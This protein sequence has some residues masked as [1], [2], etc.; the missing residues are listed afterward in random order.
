M[1]RP[2]EPT[3]FYGTQIQHLQWMMRLA[4]ADPRFTSEELGKLNSRTT[5]ITRLL[6]D[7]QER[8]LNATTVAK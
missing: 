3:Q 8:P 6:L 7:I 2:A 1:A 4:A 5:E